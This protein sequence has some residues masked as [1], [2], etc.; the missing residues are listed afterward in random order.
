MLKHIIA[1]VCMLV[2]LL[3]IKQ[4]TLFLFIRP[5]QPYDI[6]TLGKILWQT[7]S[8]F[9]KLLVV[10]NFFIKPLFIYFFVI[11]LFMLYKNQYAQK[12]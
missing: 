7:N 12:S 5:Y 1:L 6:F 9:L 8:I 10:F 2:G 4:V 3:I 11:F